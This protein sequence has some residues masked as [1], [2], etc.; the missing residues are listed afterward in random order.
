MRR[1]GGFDPAAPAEPHDHASWAYTSAAERAAVVCGWL[2]AGLDAGF[3]CLYVADAERDQLL[4]E[5]AAIPDAEDAVAQGAL[6]VMAS[7]AAYDLRR[8]IDPE[9]QLAMYAGATD[10]ALAEG[11]AG[12][13]VAADITPLVLDRSRLAS[14]LAWEQYADWY[15]ATHPLSPLCLYDK[16]RV[17]GVEPIACVHPLQGPAGPAVAIFAEDGARRV[18]G[19]ID[20]YLAPML[21]DVVR[22]MPEEEIVLDLRGVGFIDAR[23]AW[24]LHRALVRIRD[25]GRSLRVVGAS[26]PFELVWTTCGFDETLPLPS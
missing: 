7:R 21:V 10:Q 13:R 6:V 16:T 5:L 15:I 17:G 20:S 24:M 4:G 22:Q 8:P 2:G 1:H 25:T 12:L 19:E 26:P 14:H 3:R 23:S 11:Y 9:A 18:Q